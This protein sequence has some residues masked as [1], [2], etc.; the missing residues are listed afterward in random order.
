MIKACIET[1][2]RFGVSR[3]LL[4]KVSHPV[5]YIVDPSLIWSLKF[6]SDNYN[7][8]MT[9]P[10]QLHHLNAAITNGVADGTFDQPKG[11]SGKVKLASKSKDKEVC[12]YYFSCFTMD[13]RLYSH[14]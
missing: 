9:L 2:K 11:A 10:T 12:V 6:I 4:K 7:I 1:D 8:D 3:D 5:P 13:N 14:T